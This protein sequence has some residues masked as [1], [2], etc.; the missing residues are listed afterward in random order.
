M[1]F[2][3]LLV[4]SNGR[5]KAENIG[6]RIEPMR[7][8]LAL[9]ATLPPKPSSDRKKPYQQRIYLGTKINGAGI[10]AAE[11][12]A[13]K[14]GA[15]L[16]CGEFDWIPYLSP[17]HDQPVTAAEWI[18]KFKAHKLLQGISDLTWRTDYEQ[19]FARIDGDREIT[20]ELLIEIIQKTETN[21]KTRRRYCVTLGALAKFAGIDC[22]LSPYKGNYSLTAVESR[23]IPD[24]R[25][26][27]EW[28]YK[29]PNPAWQWGYGMLAAYGLR[30]EEL[31]MCE[32]ENLP[33]LVVRGTKNKQSDRRVWP[34][35]PEW[36]QTF[37]LAVPKIPK[38]KDS[39]A[40]CS[41][42][43]KD[44]GSPFPPTALRHAWAIRSME[45][46]LP[47]ELAAAQM[48]HSLDVHSKVYH[49]WID[50]RHHQRAYDLLMLRQ[51]RPRPPLP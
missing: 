51:D 8:R 20:K 23:D 32:F 7:D 16:A 35:Y 29:I 9:R 17:L 30:P 15:L 33:V 10:K 11:A 41:K 47:V 12:Q 4:L 6:V 18:C 14:I 49:R 13:R 37:D 24:D 31:L 44:Y 50:H 21:T 3:R 5:L 43:F 39:G 45:F 34:V 28:F 46:G 1:D 19:V 25:T 22:D 38:V 36:V 48:G 2:E 40:Q 27:Q 42:R 26:I